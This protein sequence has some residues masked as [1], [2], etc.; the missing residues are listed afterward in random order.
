[1][2][3][4]IENLRWKPTWVSHLGCVKG[5]LEYLNLDV[6]DAWLF[7]GT[8][9]AFVINIHE[10][11]CP[12]GP[13]AWN[14]E[15]LFKLG[16]NIGYT[17]EGVSGSKSDSDFAEKQKRAWENTK[18]A[19]DEG[20]PCYGWELD[21]PEYYVVYGYDDEGYYFSG[22]RCDFSKSP[23]PWQ[24]LGNSQIGVLE[25]Y[26]VKPGEAA[27]DART[28]KEAL[29]FALE[30]SK[31]PAKWIYPKYKAGLAGYDNWISALENG[32]A[33]R[34]GMAYNAAVWSECRNFAVQFLREAKERLGGKLGEPFDEATRHYEAVAQELRKVSDAFPFPP[35]GE[36]IED[37][38][39]RKAALKCLRAARDAEG[40]G[41]AELEKIVAAP[42][43]KFGEAS[44]P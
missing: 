1:M 8:G 39:R 34:F 11:V 23:K 18:L 41:L 37:V 26:S 33:H 3:K 2:G 10:I 31:S 38:H 15:M 35:T 40:S 9:H 32:K 5:C 27:D 12:S 24:E 28:V 14:T 22:P 43:S 16:K 20:L 42:T 7:G 30:H 44:S 19:I 6:T 29:G 13:T 4:T 36:E 25:M 21:I 17:V